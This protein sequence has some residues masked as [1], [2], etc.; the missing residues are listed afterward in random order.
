[1]YKKI[2]L[3]LSTIKHL[4]SSQILWQIIYRLKKKQFIL[5]KDLSYQTNYITFC[6]YIKQEGKFRGNQTFRFLNLENK[7]EQKIDWSY[8][9]N[10]K[11]WNYNLEYFDYL[12]QEDV[13]VEEKINLIFD[14][15]NFSISNQKKME[16]Y[17]IS[18]RLINCIKFLSLHQVSDPKINN[19]LY[20]E[21]DY[22]SQNLEY[23]ILG[24]HL[25][26]NGFALLIAS[27]YFKNDSWVNKAENLLVK[28]L[29]E[30]ILGDGSHFELSPMYHQIIFFRVLELIDWYSKWNKKKN[31]FLEY[32]KVIASRMNS[33]LENISFKNGDIP[34]FND[35]SDGIAYSTSELRKYFSSLQLQ[36]S[37]VGLKDSGYRSMSNAFLEVKIDVAQLAVDYQ[38]GH[39]HAD[40]LGYIIYYKEKPFI[41][42]Q[43]TSTYQ[44]NQRRALER[45]SAAHNTVVLNNENHSQVWSGFRVGSRAS[46][47]ILDD[48]KSFIKA[49][50]DGYLHKY[51]LWHERSFEMKSQTFE[52]IDVLSKNVEAES[53]IHFA[54]GVVPIVNENN[55]TFAHLPVLIK[56][57][58][59]QLIRIEEYQQADGYNKY[60]KNHKVI[61]SFTKKMKLIIDFSS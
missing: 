45:S 19:Y 30:Q 60:L 58:E 55:I 34:H 18:L 35:S 33:F 36:S 29:E 44:I 31:K 57:K 6:Y 26:E 37:P 38:P 22:L 16:P 54:N 11:L 17:P 15:Y 28:E 24:N 14:F 9:K 40:S 50:H 39:A 2:K 21:A 56:V 12:H 49:R 48:T 46:T 23:H 51:K 4:K 10:G 52:I 41:V 1:M 20:Q 25:L 53:H 3:L 8:E 43:G 7:F 42:E 59:F 61:I 32:L 47:E 13:S 27:A 5:D